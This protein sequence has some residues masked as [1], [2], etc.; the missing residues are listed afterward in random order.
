MNQGTESRNQDPEEAFVREVDRRLQIYGKS[1]HGNLEDPLDELVFIILSGQTEEYSYIK[2]FDRLRERFP[3][4]ELLMNA[5]VDIIA[6]TIKGGGLH[7]KKA[8]HL[9][10]AMEKIFTDFGRLSLE[11]LQDYSTDEALDYLESLPGVSVKSARCILMYA[12]MRTLFPVDTHVWRICRRLGI[13][14]A[15]PKPTSKQQRDLEEKVPSELRY[16]L[17]VNMVSHGRTTCTTYWP[18]CTECVLTDICPSSDSPDKVWGEW[19]N[20]SGAWAG[21]T[22]PKQ[23]I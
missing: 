3:R 6:A 21:Y 8:R 4:W 19:R 9:K 14:P 5:P 13:T 16:S 2:T 7:N 20:P 23:G 10:A 18:R 15:V 11:P 12:F 17:H 1:R 22:R